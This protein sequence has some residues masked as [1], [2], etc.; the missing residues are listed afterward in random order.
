MR[1]AYIDEKVFAT[2]NPELTGMVPVP[3][4]PTGQRGAELNSRMMG[5]FSAIRE[6]AVRDAAW[7]YMR[8]YDSRE[9]AVIKTKI[10]VEGGLGRFVNPQFLRLFGYPEIERLSPKGWAQTFVIAIDTGKPEPYGRNSNI[11][12]ELMTVPIQE[13]EQLALN[14]KLP[15]DSAKR[16]DVL[17]DLLRKAN[18]R[19]NE[20]MIGLVPP[21]ERTERRVGAVIVLIGILGTFA[22]ALRKIATALT[23]PQTGI[24]PQKKWNFRK[25]AWAYGLLIPALGTVFLW[26]Y[27][28]L[29]RG[30]VMAFQD[31]RLLGQSIWVGVDNFGALLFDSYWWTSVWNALR[32]SFLTLALTFLPPIILAILLQE[33][34][35]GKLLFRTIYYLPAVISGIVTV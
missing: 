14:D 22:L 15:T 17:Q 24:G 11:A 30:S 16:L 31:Y 33:A 10:M 9:A 3:L 23:P 19:A 21:K 12:L 34:P 29:V 7:E 6:P 18:T 26:Q 28:P 5:L 13:A 4:G 8:Y 20:E 25:Y 1:F 2:I 27:L 35:R 32:Y